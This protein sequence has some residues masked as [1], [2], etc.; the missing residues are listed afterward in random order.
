MQ[1]QTE[2]IETEEKTL[3]QL[4]ARSEVQLADVRQSLDDA[5]ALIERPLET[6]LNA[7]DLGRRLLNQVFFS[8]IRVGEHGDVR[9][10]TIVPAYARIIAPRLIRR[11]SHDDEAAIARNPAQIRSN[12]GPFALGPGFDR[13]KN[14]AP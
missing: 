4:L 8:E 9:E 3:N 13:D 11:R 12:P 1:R 6:Y 7:G 10:A 5:L 2:R 14:G